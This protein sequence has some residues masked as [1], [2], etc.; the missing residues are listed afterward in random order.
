[1]KDFSDVVLGSVGDTPITL[2]DL[3]LQL[4]TNLEHSIVDDTIHALLLRKAADE[5][6]ITI[7]TEELQDAADNFRRDFG[8][9][10]ATE[11]NE[12]MESLGLIIDEFER[13]VENDLL[14]SRV[15][16]KLA[17]DEKINRVFTENILDFEKVKIAKLVV[18]DEGLANEIMTQIDE[19][20][21]SFSD[22][23]AKYS[24]DKETADK[25]GFAGYVNRND[26]PDE[27]DVT[28]FA[29]DAAGLVGPVA[30]NG[31]YYLVKILEAK[32][33]DPDDDL[34]RATCTMAIFNDYMAE[35][36]Q[37]IGVKLD[38]LP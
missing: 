21:A 1:M 31:S 25:G 37:E 8:L 36:G 23:A 11:T 33:A 2:N 5:L 17:T 10:T 9:I 26:L 7:S 30:S 20:E 13:K 18:N 3:L 16:E 28:V 24:T 12:W 6:G 15:E 34:T 22:L 35:K 14:R 4:K 29:D 32:K 38:F 19:G 27:V